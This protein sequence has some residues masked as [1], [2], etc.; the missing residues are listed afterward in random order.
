MKTGF[1][2]C[3]LAHREFPVSYTGFGFAVY[4]KAVL[5]VGNHFCCTPRQFNLNLLCL[6]G[7][8]EPNIIY[9]LKESDG[10]IKVTKGNHFFRFASHSIFYQVHIMKYF[11]LTFPACF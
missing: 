1:S 8:F 10:Q 4:E 3:E 9:A 6:L 11:F 7:R 2:L 5:D